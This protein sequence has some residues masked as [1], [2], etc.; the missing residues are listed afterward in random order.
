M[1]ASPSVCPVCDHELVNQLGV[2]R[3]DMFHCTSCDNLIQRTKDGS[4][5]PIN[6]LLERNEFG[7]DRV[8]SATSSPHV[9]TAKS[10]LEIH[11]S[12]VRIFELTMSE[13]R[14]GLRTVL[15]QLE[16]RIDFAISKFTG[17]DMVSEGA[18]EGLA[19][20]REAREMCST[21]PSRK[22]GIPPKES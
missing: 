10:F 2:P 6:S 17:L 22:R 15:A 20:L 7:D 3:F 9:T 5:V 18:S 12:T 8:R 16:N 21:S 11:D 19:A 14:G 1:P 13:A 4:F